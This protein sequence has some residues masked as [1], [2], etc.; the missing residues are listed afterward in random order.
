MDRSRFDKAIRLADG[1]WLVYS[2]RI[3]SDSGVQVCRMDPTLSKRRWQARC[4]GLG[5]EYFQFGQDV[6]ANLLGAWNGVF[7]TCRTRGGV[8]G[9]GNRFEERLDVATGKQIERKVSRK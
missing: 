2:Y 9:E 8:H 3:T 1:D 6:E 7:I 5:Q 4:K